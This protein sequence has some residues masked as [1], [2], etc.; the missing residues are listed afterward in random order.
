MLKAFTIELGS[1]GEPVVVAGLL[2]K[3]NGIFVIVGVD[4]IGFQGYVPFCVGG[5]GR[6]KEAVVRLFTL[7]AHHS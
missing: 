5:A 7:E 4:H 6:P 3:E 1:D 2:G